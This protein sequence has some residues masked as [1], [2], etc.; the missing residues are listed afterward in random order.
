MDQVLIHGNCPLVNFFFKILPQCPSIN[1][2]FA[3]IFRWM[4]TIIGTKNIKINK[5]EYI[6]VFL[7]QP[8][9]P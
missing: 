7:L 5:L 6:L 3:H 8:G 4:N 2:L 9:I 1:R